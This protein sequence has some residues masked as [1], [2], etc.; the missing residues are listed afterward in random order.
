MLICS[1]IIEIFKG[2]AMLMYV[3]PV[4]IFPQ[5]IKNIMMRFIFKFLM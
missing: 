5:V 1:V 4:L 2:K 3:T